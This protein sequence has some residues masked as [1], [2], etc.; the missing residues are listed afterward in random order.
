MNNNKMIITLGSDL[1]VHL[2]LLQVDFLKEL[3]FLAQNA[4]VGRLCS[5]WKKSNS[6]K[7]FSMDLVSSENFNQCSVPPV[8]N[9]SS[10]FSSVKDWGPGSCRQ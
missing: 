4:F 10:P 7:V 9:L 1:A 5:A 3:R 6:S 2:A 8:K